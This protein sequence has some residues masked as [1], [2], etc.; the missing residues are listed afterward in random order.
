[1]KGGGAC[2]TGS[3]VTG[4][5]GGAGWVRS[6]WWWIFKFGG[7]LEL[8]VIVG[9]GGGGRWGVEVGGGKGLEVGRWWGLQHHPPPSFVKDI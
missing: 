7:S 5:R 3:G 9:L 6:G 1:M 4:E 2:S 8:A